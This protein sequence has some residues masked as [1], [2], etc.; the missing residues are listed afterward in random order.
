MEGKPRGKSISLRTLLD[1][2]AHKG[3]QRIEDV[4]SQIQQD[5]GIVDMEKWR[6]EDR[7]NF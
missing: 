3:K 4:T 5:F 2:G 1:A 7:N 6:F